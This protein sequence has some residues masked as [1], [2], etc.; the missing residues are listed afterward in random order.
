MRNILN[1][2][3][4]LIVCILGSVVVSCGGGGVDNVAALTD[5][6]DDDV[7]TLVVSTILA[8]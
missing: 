4:H 6:S 1:R 5:A 7:I 2:Y 3:R 8:N